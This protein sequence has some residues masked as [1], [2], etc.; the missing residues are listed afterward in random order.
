[1]AK[2]RCISTCY[3]PITPGV[4]LPAERYEDITND[5][6]YEVED[7]RVAEFLATGKFET[8]LVEV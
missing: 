1:M 5:D 6:I 7:S 2:L 3:M 4:E 8:V